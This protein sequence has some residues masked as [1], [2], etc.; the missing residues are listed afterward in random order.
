MLFILLVR[1]GD[2]SIKSCTPALL[3]MFRV[4]KMHRAWIFEAVKPYYSNA[5]S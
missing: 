1:Q 2:R 3:E 5:I 4:I